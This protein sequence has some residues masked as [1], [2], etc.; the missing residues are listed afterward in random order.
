[1]TMTAEDYYEERLRQMT[2][3]EKFKRI[4]DLWDFTYQMLANQIKLV[5][6]NLTERQLRIKVARRIY[7]SDSNTQKLLDMAE[8]AA[9]RE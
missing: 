4:C 2:G 6:P 9:T 3:Q 5:E 7:M 8:N 1:M